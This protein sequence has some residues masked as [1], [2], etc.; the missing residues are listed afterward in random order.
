VTEKNNFCVAT[1][2][3]SSLGN[4]E[5][6]T[7]RIW[8]I[9]RVLEETGGDKS[10]HKSEL[11]EEAERAEH[12]FNATVVSLF[13]RVYY[14]SKNGLTAAKLAMTFGGNHFKAEE[15]IEKALADVGVS[16]L[17][18]TLDDHIDALLDRAED[19]LARRGQPGG[20]QRA[21]A[22][23][24]PERSRSAAQDRRRPGPLAI[25][26]SGLCRKRVRSPRQRRA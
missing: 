14:P 12:D 24:A 7:R 18:R 3:G 4:L 22:M 16:K 13:N 11:D 6:K 17:C 5:D 20:H 15:Q 21:L 19:I 1:G 23:A 25:L 2:D 8:T 26:G 9:A 10:P